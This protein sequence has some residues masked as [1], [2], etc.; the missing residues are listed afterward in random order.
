MMLTKLVRVLR[1]LIGAIF[2]KN[3]VALCWDCAWE[4]LSFSGDNIP[5][6]GIPGAEH[7]CLLDQPLATIAALRAIVGEWGRASTAKGN[8]GLVPRSRPRA[9]YGAGDLAAIRARAVD[10]AEQTKPRI[11]AASSSSKL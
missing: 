10:A 5:C 11:S 2:F 8:G 1:I 3:V 6:I 9:S 4:L 7:H